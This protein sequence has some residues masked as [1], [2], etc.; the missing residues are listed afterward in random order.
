MPNELNSL[1]EMIKKLRDVLECNEG[2][3]STSNIFQ[4]Y[5]WYFHFQ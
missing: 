5:V 1:D 4:L 2:I 3:Y